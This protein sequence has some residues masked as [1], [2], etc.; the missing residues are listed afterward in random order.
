[1]TQEKVKQGYECGLSIENFD[2]IKEGDTIEAFLDKEE[3][4]SISL[5]RL[6]S[7]FLKN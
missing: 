4:M 6:Q 2:D 7:L 5:E 3:R 1:M